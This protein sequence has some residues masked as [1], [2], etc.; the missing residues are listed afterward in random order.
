MAQECHKKGLGVHYKRKKEEE[1]EEER[2]L[3][4]NVALPDGVGWSATVS[5]TGHFLGRLLRDIYHSVPDP[6]IV[7]LTV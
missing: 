5:F 1:E 3:L 2:F 6:H 7:Y 4:N